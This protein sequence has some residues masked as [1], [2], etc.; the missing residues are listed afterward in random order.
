MTSDIAKSTKPIKGKA[1]PTSHT[2]YSQR[3]KLHYLDWGNPDAP[4][5]LL[6][7]GNRDH[8]HNWDWVAQELCDDY[9]IIA[10]DFRG[11]GD[12]Q[13]VYGSAYR[14][15]EYIY[16]LAQLIHQQNLAPLHVIAHSLGGGVAL[17]YAGVYP[18]NIK[19]MIVIEGTGGPPGN[20]YDRPIHQKIGD[21]IEQT[22]KMAGRLPKRY[23][24]L[25]EAFERM[26]EANSHLRADQARHLTA[27]GSDQ[28]EDGSYS[29]KFDNYTHVMSPL[30][31]LPHETRELWG[32]I[33]SPVM[34]VSGSESWMDS[35]ERE[36][37]VTYFKDATHVTVQDAGHWV[38]HDQLDEFLRLTR[39]FFD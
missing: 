38:Q 7:H 30:D 4:P 37:H 6:V 11:H 2:Y 5:L 12:S 39:D 34:L 13:W 27:H 29:W 28:N 18:E 9:H 17:C 31:I 33:D 20:Y 16:D 25:E 1:S 21:W 26:H 3:M 36:K 8:C 19:K 35:V 22:R 14:R 32:R 15:S 23:E 24:N 10:P